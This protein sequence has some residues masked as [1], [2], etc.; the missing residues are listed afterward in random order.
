MKIKKKYHHIINLNNFFPEIFFWNER[1][2][3][4][5]I[6]ESFFHSISVWRIRNNA[7]LI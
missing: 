4:A 2:L 7:F 1:F 3:L 5:Y 6:T